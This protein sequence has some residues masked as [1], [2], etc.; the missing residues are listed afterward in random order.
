MY[1]VAPF[2]ERRQDL[3][4]ARHTAALI[5]SQRTEAMSAEEFAELWESLANYLECDCVADPEDDVD[6]DA[7]ADITGGAS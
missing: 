3:R 1:L 7:L 2:G 6:L 5:A 4:Q